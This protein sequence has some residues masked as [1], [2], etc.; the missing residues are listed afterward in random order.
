MLDSRD[1]ETTSVAGTQSEGC[2]CSEISPEGG[3]GDGEGKA[4]EAISC[5]LG[6]NAHSQGN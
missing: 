2:V 3:G 6:K 5:L 4:S 1:R